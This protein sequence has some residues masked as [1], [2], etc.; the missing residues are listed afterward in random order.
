MDADHNMNTDA[1]HYYQ[2]LTPEV[3][4]NAVE[5]HGFTPSGHLLALNSYENRVYQIGLEQG[6]FVI[7]KFYRQPRWSNEAILEE[8]QFTL[9]LAEQEL[10][11]IAP[12]KDSQS[13]TLFDYQGF[14]FALYP[15]CGGHRPD[16]ETP[17]SLQHIG[18]LLGRM[19]AIGRQQPFR[20]RPQL[21]VQT[22]GH[23]AI[24]DLRQSCLV[25]AE[26]THN[27]FA[28][29][30]ILVEAIEQQ[31]QTLGSFPG[32]RLHGDFH[33]GNLLQNPD[34]LF[35]VD[36]DD[37]MTGPVVQDLWLLLDGDSETMKRQLEPLLK[38]YEQFNLFDTSQ[39]ALIECLRG[40]R[41]LHYNAWIARRWDD[42]T[43]PHHFPWFASPR[44]WEDQMI[45]LRQQMERLQNSP[46]IF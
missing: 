10:P 1:P 20:H 11:I 44:H 9:E 32:Q 37:C 7:G 35:V 13:Q 43:F 18:R 26:S 27:F 41:V 33:A 23:Q 22:F 2:Q 6:G 24:E 16:L 8:H 38:G 46:V 19:H 21:S 36:L 34:G 25:P 42:P 4:L 5:G 29:A 40:L 45:D 3:I 17:E 12:L 30:E 31:M 15:R 39:L 14:R 28:A